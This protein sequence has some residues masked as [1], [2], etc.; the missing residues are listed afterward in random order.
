MAI[1]ELKLRQI[2]AGQECINVFNYLTND[3]PASV[4]LSL[5]LVSAWGAIPSAGVYPATSILQTLRALQ[6]AN[7]SYDFIEAKDVYSVVDFYGTAFNPNL[8]GSVSGESLSP[9]SAFGF[10]SNRTRSDIRRGSKR[11]VGVAESDNTTLGVIAGGTITRMAAMAT[12]LSGNLVYVD[13]GSPITFAPIIVSKE[14]Y[15]V[16]GSSPAREAYRYYPTVAEQEDHIMTS[17]IWD[18][19]TTIRSQTSRQYGRGR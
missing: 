18:Y 15:T 12:A 7:V 11:F 17:A 19:Q 8:A 2:Y 5:A 1:M 4:T 9:V 16:P 13:E 6:S 14:L 3:T 10:R